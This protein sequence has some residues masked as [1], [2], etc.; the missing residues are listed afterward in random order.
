MIEASVKSLR[1]I[2][3]PSFVIDFQYGRTN[4][5][6][7]TGIYEILC[8][9]NKILYYLFIVPYK[10]VETKSQ[11]I[12]NVDVNSIDFIEPTFRKVIKSHLPMFLYPLM[13]K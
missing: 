9:L 5:Q 1:N 10:A 8:T 11:E 4:P 7:E 12:H 13:H 2:V 6:F 3:I